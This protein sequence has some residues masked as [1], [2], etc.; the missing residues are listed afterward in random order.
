M[1]FLKRVFFIQIERFCGRFTNL[2]FCQSSEDYSTAIKEGI[3]N[4][5][6]VLHIGN[7]VDLTRF[8]PLPPA[9]SSHIRYSLGIPSDAFVVGL[10][11]RQVQEK[12]IVEFL[13]SVTFLAKR[14][15][16]L[17]VLLVGDR[18][19]SDHNNNISDQ[20]S[21]A[22]RTLGDRLLSLG[23]RDDIPQLISILDL[24][25]LPSWRE[26][27]PRTII[28][29]MAMSKPV[30]ATDIRGSRELVVHKQTGYLIP[31]RSPSGLISAIELFVN[32]PSLCY[33]Y[34]RAGY[35]RACNLYSEA[36]VLALQIS[37]IKDFFQ[38]KQA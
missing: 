32:N 4:P 28:E 2:L 22:K 38:T 13:E 30:V 10:I 5:D 9:Y 16:K 14:Y 25:C 3:A 19:N 21:I 11:A 18:L 35:L 1:P 8:K 33:S 36:S 24:F 37:K 26:G 17:Y 31:V 23:S 27:M 7:G 34:G 12:G 29:A 20:L 6:Q 15:P